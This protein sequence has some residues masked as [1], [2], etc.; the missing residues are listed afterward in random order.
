M[1][2]DGETDQ[3]AFA[4]LENGVVSAIDNITALGRKPVIQVD[5]KV[6]NKT[7]A[8][9]YIRLLIKEADPVALDPIK[10]TP[11]DYTIEYTDLTADAADNVKVP[12]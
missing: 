9:A 4:T 5:A 2:E 3:K 11:R 10:T 7:F 8:T 1:G 12:S 6:G